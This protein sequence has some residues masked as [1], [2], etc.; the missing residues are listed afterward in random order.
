ML[1]IAAQIVGVAA[2]GLYLFSYQLKKRIHIVW[3][4]FCSNVLYVLQYC[5]LGAFS[6]AVMDVLSTVLSFGA[7]RKN[8]PKMKKHG[9]L[10]GVAAVL[11]AAGIGLAV[12]VFRR[13]WI[14]LLPVA[15]MALQSAGLWC[16][17]EQSLRKFGLYGAPFWLGYN[18]I[19]KAYGT[20]LGSVLSIISITVSLVRYRKTKGKGSV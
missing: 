3:V 1:L 16:D 6:G 7:A 15:G 20:A 13:S 14:E 9:K 5:L 8:S 19:S 12:A 10:I 2:V 11:A 4:T 17:S 18:F